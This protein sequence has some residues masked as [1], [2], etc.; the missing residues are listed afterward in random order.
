MRGNVFACEADNDIRLLRLLNHSK[1]PNVEL[2]VGDA[3]T[4]DWFE[5]IGGAEYGPWYTC[6]IKALEN[7]EKGVELTI[8]YAGAPAEWDV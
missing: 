4:P 5:A 3:A 1:S 2:S 7:I 8:K 6:S